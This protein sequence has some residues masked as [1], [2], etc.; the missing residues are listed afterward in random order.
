MDNINKAIWAKF[1]VKRYDSLPFVGWAKETTRI[2][3]AQLFGELGYKKGVEI[4][5]QAGVYS[6][7][8]CQNIPN[9]EL[10]CIDP[11][12]EYNRESE[13]KAEIYYD[14]AKEKLSKYNATLMRMPSMEAVKEF[15]DNSLDF[16]YID[17][18][19]EFDQC[20]L[21]LIY[22]SP[23]VKSGGIVAGH[24]YYHFYQDGV[25]RAVNTYTSAHNIGMWYVTREKEP[26]YFWVKQ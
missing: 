4:G 16:C 8:L 12:H 15:T 10:Y 7:I 21:D 1:R 5:V 26:S 3:L 9:H 17:G 18:M 25:I 19:H 14:I 24:D 23:K 11:W 2:G 22:W 13:E 6:E 20:M